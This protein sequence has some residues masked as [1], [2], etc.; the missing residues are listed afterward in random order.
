MWATRPC[1]VCGDPFRGPDL[2]K[3]CQNA[4][5]EAIRNAEIRRRRHDPISERPPKIIP[6]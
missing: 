4:R 2:C 1:R 6:L 3:K 5:A